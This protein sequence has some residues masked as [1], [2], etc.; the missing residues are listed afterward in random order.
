MQTLLF[1]GEM[2]GQMAALVVTANH[3]KVFGSAHFVAE[4]QDQTLDRE[5]CT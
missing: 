1:E 2:V 4:E 5:V 3:E